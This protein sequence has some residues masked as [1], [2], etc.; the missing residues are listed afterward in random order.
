MAMYRFFQ[1]EEEGVWHPIKD[2]KN[3][4]E[5]A[6]RQGAK[7]L[8][9]MAVDKPLDSEDAKK[10]NS[11][12]GPLYFDIDLPNVEDAIASALALIDKLTKV[13]ETPLEAIQ[14]YASGKKGIHVLVDQRAF[15]GRRT[16]VKDLPLIYKQM[17]ADLYVS[18]LDLSPYSVGRNNTFRIANVKR[19]D[20]NYRVPV[21]F[22]ELQGLTAEGYALLVSAPRHEITFAEYEGDYSVNLSLL[23]AT[24]AER[25]VRMEKEFASRLRD[26]QQGS[27]ETI[28]DKAPPCVEA[29]A[30]NKGLSGNTSFNDVALAL[31][32][33]T[34]RAAVPDHERDR[35]FALTADNTPPSDRYPNS[36]ARRNEL[37]GKHRFMVNSPDYKFG[38]GHMRSLV[39][40]GR[41]ICEGCPLENNCKASTAAEF[42]SDMATR[43]GIAKNEAGYIKVHNGG[44]VEP[45]S[46]FTLVAEA[47]Y[48]EEQT[49]GT[50]N[51]RKGTL[52]SL[53]RMG[54][55]LGQVVLDESCWAS[56]S[57]F[58]RALEGIP[59]AYYTG[60]DAEIQKIKM[61]VFIE[62]ESMPEIYQVNAAGIHLDRRQ[63]ADV[64]TYVEPGKSLNNLSMV[65]THRLN[66][67]VPQQPS[68]FKQKGA[69][70]SDLRIDQALANLCRS[71]EKELVAVILGWY[72]SCYLKA[73]LREL[74]NQF[75]LLCLWGASGSGKSGMAELC[76]NLHGINTTQT[77]KASL[78]NLNK[79]NAIELFTSTTTVPRLCEEYNKD[80]MP[81]QHYLM[82]G[83]LFKALWN[84]E[85][86]A[87]GT[88]VQG[89]GA[90]SVQH[91]L[92]S[93]VVF[94]CEHEPKMPALCER[95]LVIHLTKVT[96]KRDP[97]R[98]AQEG[99]EHLARLGQYLM[100]ETLKLSVV[101][102]RSMFDAQAASVSQ[103]WDDRPRYSLQVVHTALQWLL[104]VCGKLRLADSAVEVRKL[105]DA[106]TE[107]TAGQVDQFVERRSPI[108]AGRPQSEVDLF[109][110]KINDLAVE[111]GATLADS[112]IHK[113]VTP[114]RRIW[115][116][117]R[118]DY[119]V[120][121]DNLYLWAKKC[122]S[123]FNEWSRMMGQ[124][125][126]LAEWSDL[127]KLVEH[128]P[129]FV[130]WKGLPDFAFGE[131]AMVLSISALK[132]RGIDVNGMRQVYD[133]LG[134]VLLGE[135][136]EL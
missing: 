74:Y 117:P 52:C 76:A 70:S 96:R 33:W 54:D 6:K 5:D 98:L 24:C 100:Q 25:L 78:P 97:F 59:G 38:C 47:S 84:S 106:L 99:R 104:E 56:K 108:R 77:S 46:T 124:R 55:T 37:E 39:K 65:D 131:P 8:T 35:I 132:E 2:G 44:K 94:M 109:L 73:H 71:N 23:Y 64:I 85:A 11:Y 80:K 113:V 91:P 121:G 10:G 16:A 17:A 9:I 43:L 36:R 81:E 107:I 72:V 49:D 20:G 82:L 32:I 18:G 101:K 125:P 133:K 61:L 130:E 13:Y 127:R 111:S 67:P 87:R 53:L 120:A 116:N 102:V 21:R 115:V 31:G 15:M 86:A 92:T 93:P 51:R 110:M 22:H 69:E 48:M 34:A 62:E 63:G 118:F 26:T 29:L 4:I 27:L 42:Y 136:G 50:G 129:Y 14:I 3:V 12:K 134:K 57:S 95:T 45:I 119:Q 30:F 58:I 19:Y 105:K 128:E 126:A 88:V 123:S 75:P 7:K 79:F 89:K 103:D 66:K 41:K 60:G 122:H 1:K 90:I 68:L 112:I 114:G 135:D 40:S 83:E 28:S